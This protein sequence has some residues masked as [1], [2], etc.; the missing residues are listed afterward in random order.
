MDLVQVEM[1]EELDCG[2]WYYPKGEL[3]WTTQED[4]EAAEKIGAVRI[5]L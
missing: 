5:L 2:S 1:L 4:A 3:V